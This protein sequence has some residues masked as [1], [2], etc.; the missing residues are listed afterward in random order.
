MYIC[1][2]F[3]YPENGDSI[4]LGNDG[5]FILQDMSSYIRRGLSSFIS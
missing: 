5:K 4:S 3:E 2:I 1:E